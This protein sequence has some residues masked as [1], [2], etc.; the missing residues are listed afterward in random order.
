[1]DAI[2]QLIR[3]LIKKHVWENY[4]AYD[5]KELIVEETRTE[6][7]ISINEG[8]EPLIIEKKLER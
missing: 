2:A 8:D 3:E 6:F 4:P 7:H 1:M 5:G